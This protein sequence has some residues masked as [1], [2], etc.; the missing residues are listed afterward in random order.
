MAEIVS[1]RAVGRK[2][3]AGARS[4]QAGFVFAYSKELCGFV[5]AIVIA[6]PD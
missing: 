2:L 1:H 6:F 4:R 3:A 5:S